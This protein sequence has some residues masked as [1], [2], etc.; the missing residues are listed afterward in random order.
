[1]P[2]RHCWAWMVTVLSAPPRPAGATDTWTLGPEG[3]A[4][5]FLPSSTAGPGTAR[6]SRGLSGAPGPPGRAPRSPRP[7]GACSSRR[8][9]RGSWCRWAAQMSQRRPPSGRHE[10]EGPDAGSWSSSSEERQGSWGGKRQRRSEPGHRGP[11]PT[12][13]HPTDRAARPGSTSPRGSMHRCPAG[14]PFSDCSV[15][16]TA[17]LTP[18]ATTARLAHAGQTP[19]RCPTAGLQAARASGGGGWGAGEGSC[20]AGPDPAPHRAGPLST[21]GPRRRR[22]VLWA[23]PR[24]AGRR[25]TL[26]LPLGSRRQHLHLEQ[27]E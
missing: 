23:R 9:S 22:A 25:E 8:A 5:T 3:Q 18:P 20:G 1:M 10:D 24:R 13:P 4:G 12:P 27:P 16:P 26:A 19:A 21:P 15:G 11:P 6:T 2:S 17:T 7:A 14:E